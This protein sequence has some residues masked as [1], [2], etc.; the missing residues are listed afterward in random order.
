VLSS[1]IFAPGT[2]G[3]AVPHAPPSCLP[4]MAEHGYDPVRR[5]W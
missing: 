1:E 5:G 2:D 4:Q 3:R